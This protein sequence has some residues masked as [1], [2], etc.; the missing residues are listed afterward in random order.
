MGG[1][2]TV[3]F[4]N[5]YPKHLKGFGLLHSTALPDTPL[6]IE[7]RNRG[8]SFIQKFGAAT[9]ERELTD[10]GSDDL[11]TR[12]NA[13][14]QFPEPWKAKLEVRFRGNQPAAAVTAPTAKAGNKSTA[15]TLPD[16]LLNLE[17][18]CSIESPEDFH[19]AR[20]RMKILAL[21]NAMEGRQNVA[22]T[23]AD[24]E[25]WLLVAA[26]TPHPDDSSRQRLLK[27]VTAVRNRRLV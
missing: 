10:A 19:A 21:K 7:N 8:I 1:Y 6:K 14:E 4:A 17:V 11:D 24:I 9:S 20:Q 5:K 2:I 16:I 26:A 27:I 12:W 15:E 18:A 25:R 23:P 22:T 3:A 13:I